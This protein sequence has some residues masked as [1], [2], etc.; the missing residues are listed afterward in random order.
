MIEGSPGHLI[1][2]LTFDIV[3]MKRLNI[4]LDWHGMIC[5]LRIYTYEH[6]FIIDSP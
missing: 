2:I 1:T 5:N 4:V 3:H 6:K